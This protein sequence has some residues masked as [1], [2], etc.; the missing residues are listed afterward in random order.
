MF[1]KVPGAEQKF[2]KTFTTI[3]TLIAISIII[4]IL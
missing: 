3:T 1:R 4:F 2:R